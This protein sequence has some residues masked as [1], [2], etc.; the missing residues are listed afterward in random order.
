MNSALLATLSGLSLSLLAAGCAL[1]TGDTGEGDGSTESEVVGAQKNFGY[2]VVTRRDVRRCA[3][4]LCG[5]FFVK[6]VNE[7]KTTCADGTKAEEC[8]VSEITYNGI[9]L[10]ERELA[11]VR[12]AVESGRGV[13]KAKTFKQNGFGRTIGVLKANEAWVGATG[14]NAEGANFFRIA[15]NGLRCITTPCPST[16]AYTLNSNQSHD[17]VHLNLTSTEIPA[18]QSD[19]DAAA[20]A[21][22]TANGILVAGGLALPKC[23]PNTN[24]GPFVHASEFYLQVTPREG[25]ACGARTGLGCNA[26]QFCSWT[27]E[28]IC[29]WADA[30]GTCSFKPDACPMVFQ[31]VCGCDGNTYGNACQAASAGMSVASNGECAAPTEPTEPAESTAAAE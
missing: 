23:M 5:G 17:I 24:C 26:D 13:V 18:S 27:A 22:G 10:S 1:D 31:P 14:S 6:R 19:L 21:I 3:A 9:G 16:T 20:T 28:G 8:Y 2:F 30:T 7:A 12:E 29:G 4:P 15:D 11:G 25:K